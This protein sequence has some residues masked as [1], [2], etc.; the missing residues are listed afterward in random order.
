MD[1]TVTAGVQYYYEIKAIDPA[2]TSPPSN[3]LRRRLQCP[4]S[5]A[6]TFF[7]NDSTF[8]GENGS[9]NL[10]DDNAIAT[11][12]TALL[13]GQAATF[14]NYSSYTDGLNGIMV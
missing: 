7:H 4:R 13:P 11:D 8:D 5:S 1:P 9:S 12:K 3:A 6:N 10:T 2:G 14:A